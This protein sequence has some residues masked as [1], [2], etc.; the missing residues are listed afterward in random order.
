MTVTMV[1]LNWPRVDGA[2][3]N[4]LYCERDGPSSVTA[5]L[6]YWVSC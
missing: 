3:T 6:P 5:C 2:V 1:S 4:P